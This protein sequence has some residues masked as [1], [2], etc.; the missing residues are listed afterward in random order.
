MPEPLP[1][2][3]SKSRL[4]YSLSY[5]PIRQSTIYSYYSSIWILNRAARAAK[6]FVNNLLR[7][8]Y[9]Y[10]VVLSKI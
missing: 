8:D 3:L 7:L 5:Y 9:R 6:D 2:L 1:L 4:E 10:N